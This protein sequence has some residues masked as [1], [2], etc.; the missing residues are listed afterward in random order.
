MY[1]KCKDGIPLCEIPLEDILAVE[2][3][4]EQSFKMKYVSYTF[5]LNLKALHLA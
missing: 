1:S 3:L 5:L 2:Q 4:E